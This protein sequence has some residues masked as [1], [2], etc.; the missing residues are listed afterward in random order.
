M[1]KILE[2]A[3]IVADDELFSQSI[4]VRQVKEMGADNILRASDG[5][6]CIQLL[7]NDFNKEVSLIVLDINMPKM[8]GLQVLKMIRSGAIE[9]ERDIPIIMLTGNT[10]REL[11]SAAMALDADSFLAKP[12]S[13][14]SLV[15]RVRALSDEIR[16]MKTAEEYLSVD[17]GAA[18]KLGA[19]DK[20]DKPVKGKIIREEE[21]AKKG[22]RYPRGDVPIGSVV[23]E[24]VFTSSGQILIGE[25]VVINDRLKRKLEELASVGENIG[26]IWVEE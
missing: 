3:I 8:N 20:D 19:S 22:R 6:E 5:R 17:I 1:A 18:L 12:V 26:F 14:A 23:S 13:K 25:G 24:P 7:E 4:V 2:G 10:D 9:C 16:V 11:V 21:T 15:N